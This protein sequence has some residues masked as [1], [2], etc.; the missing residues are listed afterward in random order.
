MADVIRMTEAQTVAALVHEITHA[1]LHNAVFPAKDDPTEYEHAEILGMPCLF[2]RGQIDEASLPGGL[3]KYELRSSHD[4]VIHSIEKKVT[5][6]SHRSGTVVL[7][8]P[9][10]L[11]DTGAHV[12]QEGEELRIKDGSSTLKQ[13]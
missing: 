13:F 8:K 11:S 12:M 1:K 4:H 2:T 3:F 5:S 6:N 9:I 7:A 10:E